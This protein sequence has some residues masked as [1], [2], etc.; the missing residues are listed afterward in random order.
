MIGA[1]FKVNID[2]IGIRE[3]ALI[4]MLGA[5]FPDETKSTKTNESK[6]FKRTDFNNN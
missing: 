1:A 4:G 6:T 3:H 2:A 5:I